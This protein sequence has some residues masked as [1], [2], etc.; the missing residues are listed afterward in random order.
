MTKR[1]LFA[2]RRAKEMATWERRRLRVVE[3]REKGWTLDKIGEHYGVSR[4]RIYQLL[5]QHAA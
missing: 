1:E 5:R 2:I 3:L 4:Q